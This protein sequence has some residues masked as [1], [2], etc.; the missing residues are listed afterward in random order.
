MFVALRTQNY[1]TSPLRHVHVTSPSNP[2]CSMF[3]ALRTQNYLTSY[4]D[5]PHI[6]LSAWRVHSSIL[7][8]PYLSPYALRTIWPRTQVC[9]CT[10]K[11]YALRSA[12]IRTQNWTAWRVH[13]S[14]HPS[15]GTLSITHSELPNLALRHAPHRSVSMTSPFIHHPSCRMFVALR[16]HNYLTSYPKVHVHAEALTLRTAWPRRTER[17]RSPEPRILNEVRVGWPRPS[18]RLRWPSPPAPRFQCPPHRFHS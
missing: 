4:S 17:A 14:I 5:T 11:L 18:R 10:R 6:V 1:L 3:V 16:T 13:P 15:C 7:H 9:T 8:A 2:S 12:W